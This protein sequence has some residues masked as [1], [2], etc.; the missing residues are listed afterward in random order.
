MMKRAII[1]GDS[2]NNTL[3]AVRSLGRANIAQVLILVCD[4]DISFVA[5]SKYLKHTHVYVIHGI[6]ECMPILKQLQAYLGKQSI[7]CTFDEAAVYVD[8][9]EEELSKHFIT[10]ARGR[11]IGVLFNKD[12][13]CRLASACGLTVPRS[14]NFSRG[15][16]ID[17]IEIGWPVLLKPLNSTKGEKED[18]HICHNRT[19]LET[20]LKEQSYCKDFILQEFIDKE[21][22]IDCIGVR[23]DKGMYIPG[24]VRKIRHYPHLIGAGAFGIFNPIEMYDINL[25]SIK[26]FL[27][28]A[29][30]F[31][32]FSVEFLYKDGKYYFMEVNF[33]NEGLAYAATCAG[34]NLHAM[35]I[36]PNISMPRCIHPTYMM[37]YSID[38]LHVKEGRISRWRWLCDFMRTRCFINASLRDPWPLLSYN[39]KKFFH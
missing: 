18:I 17:T 12:T 26:R 7:I 3:S 33:R 14:V 21:Y 16:S 6:T 15:D 34:A 28:I 22:E 25:D 37:N 36:C 20:A 8:A 11:H 38:L 4:E 2:T 5:K 24:A 23:T 9:H 35:Y 27:E 1:I 32:P 39:Y 13:Q 19:D 29:G 31:G 30:Y 10:P